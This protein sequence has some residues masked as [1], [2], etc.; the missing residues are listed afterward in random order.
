V[1][2]LADLADADGKKMTDVAA[3]KAEGIIGFVLCGI[4]AAD[5]RRVWRLLQL[6]ATHNALVLVSPRDA[7]LCEGALLAEG[8]NAARLGL[9]AMPPVAEI[10]QTARL[11]ALAEAAG[12]RVHFCRMS[13]AKALDAIAAAKSRG[14]D[15]SCDIAVANLL[16]SAESAADFDPRYYLWPPL[17]DE[18]NRAALARA[19]ADG[20]ID[21][22][23]SGHRASHGERRDAPLGEAAVAG[24]GFGLLPSLLLRWA[25]EVH[26]S[27][28]AAF[29]KAQTAAKRFG[30]DGGGEI[31]IGARADLSVLDLSA[32]WTAN[33]AA[34]S[35]F[36]MSPFHGVRLRGKTQAAICG[37]RLC[38]LALPQE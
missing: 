30:I 17:G 29:A 36:G 7:H 25:G 38:H 15:I 18:K 9:A 13:V 12:A 4:H 3:R 31:K 26:L 14:A 22:I 10:A 37:G 21:F 16:L 24:A 1:C 5:A 20:L 8:A 23:V 27:D 28:A 35:P 19:A 32:E 34:L 33:E 11:C 2:A 6:A